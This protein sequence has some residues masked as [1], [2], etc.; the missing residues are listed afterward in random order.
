MEEKRKEEECGWRDP[1][2]ANETNEA[3]VTAPT[4]Q[5]PVSTIASYDGIN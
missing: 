5:A 3:V 2:K 1:N 4:N